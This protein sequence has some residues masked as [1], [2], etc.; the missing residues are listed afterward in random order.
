[1]PQNLTVI[2]DSLSSTLDID[3]DPVADAEWYSVKVRSKYNFAGP[4]QW[5]FLCVD[6]TAVTLPLPLPYER[7]LDVRMDRTAQS[8]RIRPRGVAAPAA[9]AVLPQRLTEITQRARKFTAA[10]AVN[11]LAPD[12]V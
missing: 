9:R 6:S 12:T 3:W 8:P 10:A 4:W 11:F 5:D 1:M 7:I 2:A